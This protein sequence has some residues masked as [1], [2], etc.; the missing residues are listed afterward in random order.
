MCRTALNLIAVIIIFIHRIQLLVKLWI[1]WLNIYTMQ[2]F[3]S[4]GQHKHIL[5][6]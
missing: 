3:N 2:Y 1:E 5:Y 4:Y 6:L